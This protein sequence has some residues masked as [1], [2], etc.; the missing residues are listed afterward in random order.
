MT[1]IQSVTYNTYTIS[2]NKKNIVNHTHKHIH[3]DQSELI[4]FYDK[5]LEL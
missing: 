2:F 3:H 4:Q 5:L 1:Q